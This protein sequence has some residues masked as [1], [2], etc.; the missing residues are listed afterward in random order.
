MA[1]LLKCISQKEGRELLKEMHS[2]LCGAH[3]GIRSLVGK[4]F[5]QGFYWPMAIHD[6]ENTVKMCE[7]CQKFHNKPKSLA[8]PIQVVPPTW[9]LQRWG[10]NIVGPL[11]PAQ[12]N[13]KFTIVV[14]EYFTKWVEANPLVNITSQTV[15]KFF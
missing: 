11:P 5:R 12:G 2:G 7:A 3:I 13:Y 14:V 10:I 9:P 8:Q 4:A 6:A 1:P 15:K